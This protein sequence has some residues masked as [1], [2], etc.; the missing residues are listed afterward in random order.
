MRKRMQRRWH[1]LSHEQIVDI[2]MNAT[3]ESYGTGSL[4]GVHRPPFTEDL[5]GKTLKLLF[6]DRA[7]VTYTF[8]S[9]HSLTWCEGD[10]TNEEYYQ[11]LP[12]T[13]PNVYFVQHIRQKRQPMT[14]ISLILDL[15]T[16]LVTMCYAQTANPYVEQEVTRTFHFGT[17]DGL[18]NGAPLHD[19]T[20]DLIGKSYK[21]EY[22][23]NEIPIQHIYTSPAFYTYIMQNEKGEWVASNPA[24]YIKIR[25]DLYVFSFVEER[26]SGMQGVFLMD[27]KTLHDV[28]GFFGINANNDLKCFTLGAVATPAKPYWEK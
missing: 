15:E 2:T 8:N 1:S 17:I 4:V 27:F 20:L 21:W 18:Y 12:S 11:A 16:G 3:P 10:D 24:D 25:E 22:H 5:C 23:K 14:G 13:V 9:V 26:Q 7:S 19:Y 28:G 6:S